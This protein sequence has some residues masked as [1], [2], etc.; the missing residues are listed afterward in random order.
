MRFCGQFVLTRSL[1]LQVS[2]IHGA[3]DEDAGFIKLNEEVSRH[4]Q[5]KSD[6][7]SP[8]RRLFYLALPPSVYPIVSKRIRKHCMNQS[9]L[10]L[11]LL[12]LVSFTLFNPTTPGHTSSN[13]RS[14]YIMFILQ[15]R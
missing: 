6:D 7:G 10:F 5:E 9:A 14:L 1:V 11:S 4:E 3:Y 8:T 13:S 12:A 2:Y 15:F